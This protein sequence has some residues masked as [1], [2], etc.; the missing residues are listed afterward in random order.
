MYTIMDASHSENVSIEGSKMLSDKWVLWAHLPHDTDWSLNSY[1]NIMEIDTVEGMIALYK[2]LPEK[3]VKNCMLFLMRKGVIPM[4]EDKKNRN[5]GCFSYKIPNK[6]VFKVWKLA[7]FS[8]VGETL[9]IGETMSP[10]INGITISP[11]KSFCIIKI[12]I[13][14]CEYQNTDQIN[15]KNGLIPHGCIFKKHKPEY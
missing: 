3:M 8:L 15:S 1:K 10:H 9:S 11:K 6:N 7:S 12:W 2:V 4:W 13:D 14:S 5:G